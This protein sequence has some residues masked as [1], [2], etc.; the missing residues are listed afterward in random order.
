VDGTSGKGTLY[1]AKESRVRGS[2]VAH[3]LVVAMK[4]G[5]TSRAKELWMKMARKVGQETPVSDPAR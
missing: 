2:G 1:N 5:N 4:E 3:E